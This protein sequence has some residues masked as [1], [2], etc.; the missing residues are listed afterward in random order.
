MA[1]RVGDSTVPPYTVPGPFIRP[2][3]H[4]AAYAS[5]GPAFNRLQTVNH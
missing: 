2:G 3:A 1:G 4:A 5:G